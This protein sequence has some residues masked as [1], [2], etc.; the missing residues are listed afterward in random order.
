[1]TATL[2]TPKSDDQA[3]VTPPALPPTPGTSVEIVPGVR[4]I[5]MPLPIALDHINL[6]AIEDGDGWTL[7]DTGINCPDSMAIWDRIA[8]HDLAGR[9]VKR[10]IVTHMHADHAGLAG[11][12]ANRFA[13]PLWMADAEYAD[14]QVM[15]SGNRDRRQVRD[16]YHRAG[17]Q[18]TEIE[19]YFRRRAVL[20]S[21]YCPLPQR[22]NRM[23]DGD[24]FL[25]N[26]RHWRVIA[27]GGHSA[28]HACLHCPDLDIFISGDVVLPKISSNVS[29]E[30]EAPEADPLGQWFAT[31]DR[32]RADVPDSVMVLP[33]HGRCFRGLHD[34][35]AT[36]EHDQRE[37][38]A[39]LAT[40][41]DAP[42]RP[43]AL[44]DILF[45]RPI[46]RTDI[47]L[48]TLATGETL[49]LLNHLAARGL[50][51]RRDGADGVSRF[52]RIVP[53]CEACCP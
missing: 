46:S 38:L 48:M 43:D 12:L 6:W 25:I 21:Y 2:L 18:A 42:T 30:P 29:V 44:F 16:F 1:M 10:L 53:E 35:I 17:W 32:I 22:Y 31:L 40:A 49:A 45:S 52:Q 39:R 4:W 24:H 26:G 36:L 34:R 41:L 7:V 13:C 9:P 47:S 14:A 23:A 5:R 33:S 20:G 11:W 19:R 8:T 15:V 51:A 28:E 50:V 37:V 3:P 27:G